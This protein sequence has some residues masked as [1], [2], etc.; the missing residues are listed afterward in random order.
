MALS[1]NNSRCQSLIL[2]VKPKNLIPGQ[3]FLIQAGEVAKV[4]IIRVIAVAVDIIEDTIE[5]IINAPDHR[6]TGQ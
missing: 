5:P 6:A 3:G 2:P 1:Q 4:L